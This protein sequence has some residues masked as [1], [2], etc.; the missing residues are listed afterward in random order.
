MLTESDHREI[1]ELHHRYYLSTD[2]QDVDGFMDCWAEDGFEGFFS[3][4]GDF[5]TR[6]SLR[7][8][9]DGHVHGDGM[10]VGKRHINTNL[11]VSSDGDGR[12]LATSYMIVIDVDNAPRIIATGKY[13]DSV[14]VKTDSG[15]KFARRD[16]EVDPGYEK[17]QEPQKAG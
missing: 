7:E 2:A 4:S 16:L 3:P 1:K 14:C 5:T 17:L 13:T 8:F 9:E 6:E 12:A 15:W 10:A 11:V